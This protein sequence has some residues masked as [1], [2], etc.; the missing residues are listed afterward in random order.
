MEE[1]QLVGVREETLKKVKPT[2]PY[3]KLS[4]EHERKVIGK[5]TI[6]HFLKEGN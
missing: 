1:I 2:I 6:S 3:I 4:L 5:S